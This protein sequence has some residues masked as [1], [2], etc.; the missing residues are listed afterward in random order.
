MTF[1]LVWLVLLGLV[2]LIVECDQAERGRTRVVVM[3][4]LWSL[5][6]ITYQGGRR[7]RLRIDVRALLRKLLGL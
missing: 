5:T 1:S 4:L 7:W 2:P 6:I 3:A